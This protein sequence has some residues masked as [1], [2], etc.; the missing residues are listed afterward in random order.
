LLSI[1][2]LP[3]D[4]RTI[5]ILRL[6]PLISLAEMLVAK[7]TF[8]SRQRGRMCRFQYEMLLLNLSIFIHLR[9]RKKTDRI[10]TYSITRLLGRKAPRHD[11]NARMILSSQNLAQNLRSEYFPALF[12]MGAWLVGSN[13]QARV[14]PENTKLSHTTQITMRQ[15]LL[16]HDANDNQPTLNLVV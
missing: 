10:H 13:S 3:V 14:Q 11:N 1:E 12:G 6:Q 7:K 9:K 4:A 15:M 8:V 16:C 2:Y 5:A